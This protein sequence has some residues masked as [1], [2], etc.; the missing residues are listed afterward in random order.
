MKKAVA[1][2]RLKEL[3][4]EDCTINSTV[5]PVGDYGRL[6]KKLEDLY[7]KASQESGEYN[8]DLMFALSLYELT[9]DETQEYYMTVI[10]AA[11]ASIWRYISVEVVPEIVMDRWKGKGTKLPIDHFYEK[12]NRIYLKSLWWYIHLAWQG[13]VEHTREILSKNS[14]DT[15]VNLVER[16]G[17]AGYQVVLYREIMRLFADSDVAVAPHDAG[18]FRKVMKMHTARFANLEPE[19]CD[20]GVNG[21]VKG[22]FDYFKQE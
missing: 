4:N 3:Y 20:G 9:R 15:I 14:T 6:R 10:E 18:L 2:E 22:L 5:N 8:K 16:A 12:P 19:L 7:K 17:K 1:A 11:D 13:D 21:Y